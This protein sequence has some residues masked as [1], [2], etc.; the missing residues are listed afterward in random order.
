MKINE[1]TVVITADV[2]E[3]ARSTLVIGTPH[4]GGKTPPLITATHSLEPQGRASPRHLTDIVLGVVREGRLVRVGEPEVDAV[5]A[6]D[7]L[8]Y[9][10]RVHA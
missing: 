3:T 6:S 10:R 9:I 1:L 4:S 2:V 5:E 8:L 7:K